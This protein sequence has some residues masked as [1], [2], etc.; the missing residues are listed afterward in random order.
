MHIKLWFFEGKNEWFLFKVQ[1]Y[2]HRI[3]KYALN[4]FEI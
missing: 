4:P 3:V 1:K 2:H